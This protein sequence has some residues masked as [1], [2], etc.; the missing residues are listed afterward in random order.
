MSLYPFESLPTDLAYKEL[1]QDQIK[2]LAK[3]IIEKQYTYKKMSN[4]F[5][6]STARLVRYVS[7][8]RR[9]VD[10][11]GKGGRHGVLDNISIKCIKFML[12][13]T[14]HIPRTELKALIRN[15]YTNSYKRKFGACSL[16]PKMALSTLRRYCQLFE[17]KS[18]SSPPIVM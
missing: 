18:T 1:S 7:M 5:N 11:F 6:I 14:P 3:Q 2:W 10:V 9:G 4:D 8:T 12:V 17:R 15:E 13:E 16:I